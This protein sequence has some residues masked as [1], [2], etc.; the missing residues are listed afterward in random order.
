MNPDVLQQ[1]VTEKREEILALSHKASPAELN[2]Q[3]VDAPPA[4][5]FLAALQ[6]RAGR[7]VIAEIKRSSPSAG[8]LVKEVDPAQRAKAY[9]AGG[10]AAISVLTDK[11]FFGGSI[12][13]LRQAREACSLPVLR[14]DFIISLAQIY[15]A[16]AAGAD[17]V[18]L[19]AAAL[20]Q[21]QM[22]ELYECT[23]NLGMTPLVEIHGH[24]E[25]EPVLSLEP[26]LIGINNRNLKSL[27]VDL[28]VSL[29]LRPLIPPH[30]TVVAESGVKD[31]GDVSFLRKGG[32]DAFLVGTSLM[33]AD[34][35]Q[36]LLQAMINGDGGRP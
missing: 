7:A 25:L 16:R 34:D 8:R 17:A 3:A 22:A 23:K 2:S 33:C 13:D 21:E 5:D 36:A 12:D 28:A 11:T 29:A 14:K 15:E 6:A 26:E 9:E 19:I 30:I 18:L 4:R 35:P 24:E 27:K 32:L 31:S 10:A 1:I 20:E